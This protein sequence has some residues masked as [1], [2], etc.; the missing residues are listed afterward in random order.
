MT[1]GDVIIGLIHNE[2]VAKGQP[3]WESSIDVMEQVESIETSL[4]KL[5]YRSR[6]IAFSRDLGRFVRETEAS[7]ITLAFNL[8]ES[9]DD[10]PQFV[11]HPAAVLELMNIPFTGS[12][13][14]ALMATTDKHSFKMILRAAGFNTP[15]SLL[16]AGEAEIH[17]NHMQFPVIL[18]PQFQDAS[19]GIDQDSVISDPAL[20]PGACQEFFRLYGPIIIEEYID[21]TEFNISVIGSSNPEV[22]PVAE[23]DFTGFPDSLYRIV[24]YRAKWEPESVEYRESRRIFPTLPDDLRQQ[25]SSLS[26]ACYTLFGLRDYGRVDLRLDRSG[27]IYVL[28][29]NANPCLSPD[30]GFPAAAQQGGLDYTAMVEKL[31]T[32]VSARSV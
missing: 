16:F 31:L 15:A 9:V 17:C 20:L 5:G 28:E 6:R 22:F 11:A 21:G 12:S 29:I 2:P 32:F 24:G 4:T 10:N 27:K 30:A 19:I 23:I 3:N 13:S 8:C 25:M 14:S 18:K 26:S 1:P 7:G